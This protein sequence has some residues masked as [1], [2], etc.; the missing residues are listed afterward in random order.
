MEMR[1]RKRSRRSEG[2]HLG[3]GDEKETDDNS[4]AVCCEEC[5]SIERCGQEEFILIARDR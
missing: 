5:N 1:K 3:H 2:A 4:C